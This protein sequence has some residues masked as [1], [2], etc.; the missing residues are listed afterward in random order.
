MPWR[1]SWSSGDCAGQ[2]DGDAQA[3]FDPQTA[4]IFALTRHPM[5]WGIGLWAMLHGLANGDA[6]SLIFFGALGGLALGGTVAIDAKKKRADSDAWTRLSGATSNLPL[7]ALV[8]GR[9]HLKPRQLVRP[10]AIGLVA[11][12]LFGAIHHWLFGAPPVS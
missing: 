9:A 1:S 12:A 8:Q 4:G 7:L 3:D 6:G 10:I 5:M 11:Y 2:S